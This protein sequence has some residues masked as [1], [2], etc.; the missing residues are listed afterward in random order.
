MAWPGL[1]LALGLG[2]LYAWSGGR[3][4]LLLWYATGWVHHP[5]Q[6]WTASL[7]HLSSAHLL[8]NLAALLALAVLGVFLQVGRSAAFACLL[9]WPTGTLALALWPEI[10]Y[11]GGLSGLLVAMLAVLAVFAAGR[12]ATRGTGVVLLIVLAFKLLTEHAWTQP[13]AFDPRWG[14]NVVLA[15][16]LSGALAGAL[17]AVA[18]GLL[19]WLRRHRSA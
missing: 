9:A 17:C 3:Q 4:V 18:I 6:L 11:Y 12:A 19:Q 5:W 13:V 15:A 14:F 1:C 10:T 2:S 8:I 7:A 16:H